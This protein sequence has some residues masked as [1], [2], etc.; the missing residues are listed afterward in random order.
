MNIYKNSRTRNPIESDSDV[1]TE[2]VGLLFEPN[3]VADILAEITGEDVEV[4]AEGENVT[5]T[6]GEDSWEVTAEP[7]DEFVEASTRMSNHNRQVAASTVGRRSASTYRFGTNMSSSSSRSDGRRTIRK[8][9]PT[10]LR[11]K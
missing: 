7:D 1:V 3:D 8:F 6:I 4:N 11:G 2:V 5:I 10:Y 9:P